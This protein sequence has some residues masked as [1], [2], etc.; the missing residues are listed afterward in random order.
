MSGQE[1]SDNRQ[2]DYERMV[3]QERDEWRQRAEQAEAR[4]AELE[5]RAGAGGWIACSER[6]PPLNTPV[7]AFYRGQ[8]EGAILRG[9][10]IGN[11]HWYVGGLSAWD[12]SVQPTH[13]H[14]LPKAPSEKREA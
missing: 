3:E 14:A 7:A 2:R 4:V 11:G 8:V 9:L 12:A 6:M 13:W 1:L 5:A 10:K